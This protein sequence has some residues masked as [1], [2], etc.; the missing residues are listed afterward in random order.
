MIK[1]EIKSVWDSFQLF[2]GCEVS[3]Q[4]SGRFSN[5]LAQR[6][7]SYGKIAVKLTVGT[8]TKKL[9]E[10][11]YG[12]KITTPKKAE[13][14]LKKWLKTGGMEQLQT[15]YQEFVANVVHMQGAG[16]MQLINKKITLQAKLNEVMRNYDKAVARYDVEYKRACNG[17]RKITVGTG[18]YA[19]ETVTRY[20][21]S[22]RVD[23]AYWGDIEVGCNPYT[24]TERYEITEQV[25]NWPD[26]VKYPEEAY[27]LKREIAEIDAELK[28][29]GV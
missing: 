1:L 2:P 18:Q 10:I 27:E 28:K 15:A 17:E 5:G 6:I 25:T 4:F 29:W 26:K 16:S 11:Q 20:T 23:N 8:F 14:A 3:L 24:V 19:S 12:I 13:T 9:E 22:R 7:D 21:P